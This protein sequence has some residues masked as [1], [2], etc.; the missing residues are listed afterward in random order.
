MRNLIKVGFFIAVLICFLAQPLYAADT[1]NLVSSK[2]GAA[3]KIDGSGSD[4]E[5]KSAKKVAVEA[6]DGPEITVQSVHTDSEIFFLIQVV[7]DLDHSINMDQ[8][9]YDGSKWTVKQE[10]R[11]DEKWAA[12]TDRF[13]F[14]W[15]ITDA[16]QIKKNIKGKEYSFVQKGCATICHSPEKEDKMYLLGAGQ[17]TDIWLWKSSLT[18]PLNYADDWFQDSTNTTVAQEADKPKR[19]A[20]AQKGDEALGYVQNKD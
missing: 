18:N 14:Q 15:P 16:A 3:P 20:A 7:G 8:W 17:T 19:V 10:E 2:V 9:V 12:D 6:E 4:A 1:H 11:V 13:G 5:W